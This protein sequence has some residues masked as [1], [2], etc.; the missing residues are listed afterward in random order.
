[1]HEH[2]KVL[3]LIRRPNRG[4]LLIAQHNAHDD[5]GVD[6]VSLALV[7]PVPTSKCSE[8]RRYLDHSEASALQRKRRLSAKAAGAFDSDAGRSQPGGPV[9]E[10]AI[11]PRAY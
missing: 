11:S 6:R 2:S 7:A 1:V 8:L 3:E 10:L 5:Q 9:S 4:R